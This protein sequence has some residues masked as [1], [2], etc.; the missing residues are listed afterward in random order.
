MKTILKCIVMDLYDRRLIS[1]A[2]VFRAFARHNL[3]SE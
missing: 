2:T 3:R 1:G